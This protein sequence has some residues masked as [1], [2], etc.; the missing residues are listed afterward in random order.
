MKGLFGFRKSCGKHGWFKVYTF[1]LGIGIIYF[2]SGAGIFL[3]N[4]VN[5]YR[6]TIKIDYVVQILFKRK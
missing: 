1:I 3:E 2:L 5:T 6:E 4:A